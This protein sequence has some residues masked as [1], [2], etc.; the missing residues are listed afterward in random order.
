MSTNLGWKAI[1]ITKKQQK[2]QQQKHQEHQS[3]WKKNITKTTT[4]TT[5]KEQ[6][7][8]QNKPPSAW[9]SI[10][11]PLYVMLLLKVCCSSSKLV[12][13]WSLMS[14]N[15]GLK[16]RLERSAFCTRTGGTTIYKQE[17]HDYMEFEQELHPQKNISII[18][19]FQFILCFYPSESGHNP[20]FSWLIWSRRL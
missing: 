7:Q 17:N 11:Y 12:S 8:R 6:K 10:H 15:L 20:Y 18:I 1:A 2:E 9:W 19:I 3:K 13:Y 5:T 16:V 14:N 4:T